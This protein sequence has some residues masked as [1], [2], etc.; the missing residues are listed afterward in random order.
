MRAET[1]FKDY[2]KMK[3][4]M[5]F[6]E[7]QLQSFSGLTADDMIKSMT[8]LGESE[9][10]RVQT[11]GTSDQTFNIAVSYRKRLHQENED[12][13]KFLYE[14]YSDI[15]KEIDFFE[16]GIRSMGEKKADILFEILDGELTWD[17][18]SIQYGISRTSIYRFRKTA[19]EY[20][21]GLYAQ[22]ERMEI[23][24]MLS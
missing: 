2:L 15:K 20:M 9:G 10:D 7:L 21:E 4:E 6:L 24:Y 13:C 11:S 1:M 19:M 12:Y 14:K 17:E 23:E 8:F 16:N 3:R 5:G 22:R 18:I